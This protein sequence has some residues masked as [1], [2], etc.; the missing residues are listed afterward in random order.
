MEKVKGSSQPNALDVGPG[1]D[2]TDRR[3]VRRTLSEHEFAEAIGVSVAS[4][5]RLRWRGLLPHVRIGR[6]VLYTPLQVEQ[7]LLDRQKPALGRTDPGG[8]YYRAPR[9]ELGRPDTQTGEVR[10]P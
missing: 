5:R 4:I 2:K 3:P 10:R 8:E 1:V 7:F 9:S 6:R